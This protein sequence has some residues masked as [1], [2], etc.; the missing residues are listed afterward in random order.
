MTKAK[1]A[2]SKAMVQEVFALAKE[3]GWTNLNDQELRLIKTLRNTTYHGRNLVVETA[4]AMQRAYP[5]RWDSQGTV[6]ESNTAT[7]FPA[8]DRRFFTKEK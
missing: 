8:N 2:P 7:P 6:F 1:K 5:W 3:L 4:S